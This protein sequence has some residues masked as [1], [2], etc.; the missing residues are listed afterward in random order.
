MQLC[1]SLYDDGSSGID[2]L[3][4]NC[5]IAAEDKAEGA[6]VKS[7]VDN[8]ADNMGV[9]VEFCGECFAMLKSF[10]LKLHWTFQ[11]TIV[12]ISAFTP[13]PPVPGKIFTCKLIRI[14][15]LNKVI[16]QFSTN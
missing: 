1:G 13:P 2:D 5:E 11:H 15:D 4:A 7:I 6:Y 14:E 9:F 8:C 16:N 3:V 10:N 12:N